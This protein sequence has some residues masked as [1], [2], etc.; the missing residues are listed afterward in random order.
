MALIGL[1][2]LCLT[3]IVI[4]WMIICSAELVKFT[5]VLLDT[6]LL[7]LHIPSKQTKYLKENIGK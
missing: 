2:I 3:F 7:R 4:V 5:K 6:C 1:L